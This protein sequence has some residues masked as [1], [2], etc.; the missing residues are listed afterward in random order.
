MRVGDG[1]P[2]PV[3]LGL[4][5]GTA[6]L[7]SP[8]LALALGLEAFELVVEPLDEPVALHRA[9]HVGR[10]AVDPQRVRAGGLDDLPAATGSGR[11][12]QRA[13][14]WAAFEDGSR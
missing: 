8:E 1:A 4:Q 10:V 14:G 13:D 7:G 3:G 12:A 9:L 6:G 5:L 2:E 11:R